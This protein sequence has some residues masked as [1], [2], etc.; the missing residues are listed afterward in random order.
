MAG[1]PTGPRIFNGDTMC[2][3]IKR[4]GKPCRRPKGHS[5]QHPGRGKCKWHGGLKKTGDKRL[6]HGLNSKALTD[7][8]YGNFGGTLG[9]SIE[10][11]RKLNL[12]ILD[13][14]PEVKL[15]RGIIHDI[16]TRHA[17][18]QAANE[19]IANSEDP[20]VLA[21]AVTQIKAAMKDRPTEQMNPDV[22]TRLAE[23]YVGMIDKVHKIRSTGTIT[24]YQ[25]VDAMQTHEKYLGM[26]LL[27]HLKDDNETLK[28]ILSDI[29]D[30]DIPQAEVWLRPR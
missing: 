21:G 7:Q 6:K 26:I 18:V 29:A 14:E 13:A 8:L 19:T 16:A 22:I 10:T 28:A 15:V 4:N 27:K 23:R 5:T 11:V 9:Q 12:D 1:K 20:S 3:T 2:G 25:F 30:I 17:Q 24:L